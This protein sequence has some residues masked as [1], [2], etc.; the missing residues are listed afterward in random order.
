M[1][2]FIFKDKVF[3]ITFSY[4]DKHA[5]NFRRLTYAR[6]ACKITNPEDIDDFTWE[7]LDEC[8]SK[9]NLLLD[10]FT[11]YEGK[12]EAFKK[13]VNRNFDRETRTKLWV[14]FFENN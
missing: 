12:K 6:L 4:P 9:C 10:Y 13:L 14:L 2:E 3:S 11:K 8:Y 1:I 5:G 7:T